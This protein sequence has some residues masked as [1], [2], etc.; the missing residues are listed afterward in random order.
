M[1][2]T[3]KKTNT[4]FFNKCSEIDSDFIIPLCG[5]SFALRWTRK[6]Y[7]DRQLIGDYPKILA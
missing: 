5:F 2:K 7:T 4:A 3:Y 1:Q 6:P